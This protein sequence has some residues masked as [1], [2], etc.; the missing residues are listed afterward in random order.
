[1]TSRRTEIPHAGFEV[2]CPKSS[3][4]T[5][6]PPDSRIIALTEAAAEAIVRR[7]SIR[8]V[9]D[10]SLPRCSPSS[11]APPPA[12]TRP[13]LQTIDTHARPRIYSV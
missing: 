3:V 1:V 12:D 7:L 13:H 5:M 6:V 10:A 4:D 9:C 8:R 2:L 11:N